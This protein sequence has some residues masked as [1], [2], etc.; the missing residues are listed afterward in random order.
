M[1]V[2][3][4]AWA[5]QR[6]PGDDF[7]NSDDVQLWASPYD[8]YFGGGFFS[9]LRAHIIGTLERSSKKATHKTSC[10]RNC[11]LILG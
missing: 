5:M 2:T 4:N 10:H 1:G 8:I 11:S 6:L 9:H 3:T 7:E